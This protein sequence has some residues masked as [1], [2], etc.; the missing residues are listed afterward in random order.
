MSGIYLSNIVNVVIL[1]GSKVVIGLVLLWIGFKVANYA[2]KKLGNFL[3]K[4]RVDETIKRFMIPLAR[5]TLK[6]LLVLALV[7]YMGIET[8]SVV[9]L[10]GAAGFAIG[11][12]FQGALSNFAGGVL[13]IVLKPFVVGDFIE[14][15]GHKGTVEN[16]S[17]FYTD[18]ITP[19]NRMTV[20]P[21]SSITS[22]SLTNYSKLSTRRVDLVVGVAYESDV[23]EVKEV[24]LE[25]INENEAVLDSPAPFVGIGEYADSSINFNVRLW[26][27][28]QDYWKVY[29]DFQNN[30]KDVFE[31]K[32]IEFPYP[33]IDLNIYK[34]VKVNK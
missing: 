14:V 34:D 22:S 30:V 32:G 7:N 1:Y 10:V 24:I 4:K 16:I 31:S 3:D 21:N 28:S 29:Y 20:I 5:I 17:I 27:N 6:G 25:M 8:T 12:A 26:V 9:A 19:D 15:A 18:L 2:V 33:H 23:K 11:L 13:L